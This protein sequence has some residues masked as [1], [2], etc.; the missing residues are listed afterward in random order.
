MTGGTLKSL[1]VKL[2]VDSKDFDKGMDSA[3]KKTGTL[4]KGFTGLATVG[5]GVLLGAAAGIGASAIAL[6][7][8][9]GPASDLEEAINAVNV[10][11]ENGADEILAYSESAATA[12]GLSA[13]EF[14]QMSA[15]MG[16]MLGNVGIAEKQLG[17]ETISLMER[18][19]D[20]A[21]IFNTDVGQAFAAIQSAIKGE[22]N[23]LE[24]FGVKMNQAAIDAKALAMGLVDAN[25]ELTDSARAQAALAL[26]YEQTDKVAGDFQNTSDGLANSQRILKATLEDTKA[27]VG[28][29]LLPAMESLSKVIKDIA[30]SP[31]FQVFL[32]KLIAGVSNLSS[33]IIK[34]IP[35]MIDNFRKLKDFLAENKGVVVAIFAVMGVAVAAFVYTTVIPALIALMA[36]MWPVL[37]IMAVVA[38]VAYLVY[39]AWTNN[40]GGIQEKVAAAKDWIVNAFTKLKEG[41]LKVWNALM[42][43]LQPIFDA[44]RAAFEGDWITFGAK[45]REAWDNLWDLVKTAIS[46]AFAFI[47]TAVLEF[48]P[49]IKTWFQNIDWGQVG[50]NIIKGI[51]KGITG[52]VSWI[53]NA[54]K[55]AA[56]AA[57]DAAKGFLGIN[58]PSALFAGI[59]ENMMLGM[60]GGINATAQVPMSITQEATRDIATTAGSS[61]DSRAAGA[62]EAYPGFDYNKLAR[63]IRDSFLKVSE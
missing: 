37:A 53:K 19:S 59:G 46:N 47:K 27:K 52:A 60:A 10:V 63:L 41:V 20:M 43:V 40:W 5:K 12:V 23:P 14:N 7:S 32:S 57:F 29:A 24:Q 55:N 26:V 22:F 48:L 58:S 4:T 18:A 30:A 1:L 50:L 16:A 17:G 36:A 54:A 62:G 31:E 25:G 11:F 6:G 61:G 33:W 38:A 35:V 3:E 49:K 45:I 42:T 56:Q 39:E 21:S 28:A 51:A 34:T 9:I 13:R 2:G 8:T 15:E 44:F